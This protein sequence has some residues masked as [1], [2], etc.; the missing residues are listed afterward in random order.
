MAGHTPEN[1]TQSLE[2]LAMDA[3]GHG[4]ILSLLLELVST[5][6]A[7]IVARCYSSPLTLVV[8]QPKGREIPSLN[9]RH[10]RNLPHFECCLDSKARMLLNLFVD[11]HHSEVK[12]N[13]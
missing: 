10:G 4:N 7:S 2:Y 5:A 9:S 1:A 13:A 8:Q 12:L 6:F 11:Q 3:C